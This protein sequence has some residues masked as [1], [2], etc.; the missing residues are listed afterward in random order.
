MPSTLRL[1]REKWVKEGKGQKKKG[2]MKKRDRG[3]KR[4]KLSEVCFPVNEY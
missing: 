3:I 4:G 2:E 1:G